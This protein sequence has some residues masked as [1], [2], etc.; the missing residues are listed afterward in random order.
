MTRAEKK[1]FTVVLAATA[2]GEKLPAVVIFK[3]CSGLLGAREYAG[4]H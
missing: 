3:E 1:G 2:A 4:D